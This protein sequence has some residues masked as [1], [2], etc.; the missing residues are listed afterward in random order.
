[1]S[2][3]MVVD[4]LPC[5]AKL[6]D[7]GIKF[8]CILKEQS[9]LDIRFEIRRHLIPFFNIYELQIP[10]LQVSN[11]TECLFLNMIALEQC[12]YP[13]DAQFC[14]YVE[15]L[16]YL[17]NT[18]EVVDLL[19][20]NGIISNY[21]GDNASVAMMFNKLNQLVLTRQPTPYYD[22]CMLLKEHYNNP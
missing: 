14:S 3:R 6:H 9:L 8:K 11:E 13:Y 17:I 20:K 18:K 19:V 21:T 12:L 10:R 7:S 5:A 1:M 4:D 15:L 2:H 22:I 16:N